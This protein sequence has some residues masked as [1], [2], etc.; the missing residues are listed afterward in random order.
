MKRASAFSP[1]HVTGL[2]YMLDMEEDPLYC[3]SLGAGFSLKKG[4]LTSVMHNSASESD[5]ITI[6]S[7]EEREAPVSRKVI[8]LFFNRAAIKPEG[9]RVVHNIETPQGSGFGS[10]GSGALSLAFALN[11]LYGDPL[12]AIEASRIA[13]TA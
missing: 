8:E 1:G 9:I 11:R 4:A 5:L 2:F 10:S 13:H 6:N 12:S 3:G 7:R